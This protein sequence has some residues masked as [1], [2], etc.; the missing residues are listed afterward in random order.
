MPLVLIMRTSFTATVYAH[1]RKILLRQLGENFTHVQPNIPRA[2]YLAE[3]ADNLKLRTSRSAAAERSNINTL[4]MIHGTFSC[5]N[6]S[7][8]RGGLWYAPSPPESVSRR[9][10]H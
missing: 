7:M 3:P 9:G 1:T 4:R 10:A 5:R 2:Q 6:R 8:T